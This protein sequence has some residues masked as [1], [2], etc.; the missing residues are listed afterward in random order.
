MLYLV[1]GYLQCGAIKSQSMDHQ[2][3]LK[4][5][6]T[7]KFFLKMF[8]YNL[9]DMNR[10]YVKKVK[11][12]ESD[13]KNETEGYG[14]EYYSPMQNIKEFQKFQVFNNACFQNDFGKFCY[15]VL[16]NDPTENNS[17]NNSSNDPEDQQCDLSTTSSTASRGF[18]FWKHN[19]ENNDKYFKNELQTRSRD[20]G[21][22]SKMSTMW[23]R[24]FKIGNVM[25]ISA[26]AY[27]N[28]LKRQE[29]E[30]FFNTNQVVTL[31]LTYSSC[32]FSIATENRFI[33]QRK[34]DDEEQRDKNL[35]NNRGFE[36]GMREDVR[37]GL[38]HY[39]L[40]NDS[41]FIES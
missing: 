6:N 10:E 29:F 34:L 40:E 26:I 4:S 15:E 13:L 35:H 37:Q 39:K 20:L 24:D 23:L 8:I 30:T 27:R 18:I 7:A 5:A 38:R 21:V 1:K 22:T 31:I 28:L 25:H 11:N 36:N 19:F 32:L 3:A 17:M 14:N 2:S 16:N 12:L 41:N 33:C 9:R